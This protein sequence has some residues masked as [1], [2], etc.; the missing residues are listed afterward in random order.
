MK[1]KWALFFLIL[2]LSAG[3]AGAV[4][5]R[6]AAGS[7]PFRSLAAENIAAAQVAVLPPDKSAQLDREGI[8]RLA[9]I[10]RACTVYGRDDSYRQYAGQA[11]IFT[12]RKTDGSTLTV[13]AYNPFL[14]IDGEGYR[15]KYEPCQALNALGN[16]CIR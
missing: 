8:E 9:G 2:V 7:Q 16:E 12:I 14:V 3:A 10:L 5:F 15:T 4:V 13:Q 11:V 6:F 1:K